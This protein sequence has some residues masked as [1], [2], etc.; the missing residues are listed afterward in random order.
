M[1]SQIGQRSRPSNVGILGMEV[2]FPQLYVDQGDLEAF[3]KAG[4]GKYTIGLGQA[5][6]SFVNDREDVNSISMTC[7][8]NLMQKYSVDP[9]QVGRLEVGTETLLDKSKSLKTQLMSL[10]RESGNHDV[11]GVTS[12]HACYG[13]TNAIFNTLNWVESNAWDGRLGIV[14]SSDVSV[15]PK[16]NARPTGGAGCVALL[17]GPE[18]PI[19]VDPV[20]STFVDHAWDF[21]KPN[22][23]KYSG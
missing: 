9:K 14:I 12:I 2:Y 3:D 5:K 1:Q 15:Y 18:A 21:Y 11:E 23:S 6:M 13:A 19:V 7:L 4:K 8:K 20:R 10:F 16:G 17:I 22:P